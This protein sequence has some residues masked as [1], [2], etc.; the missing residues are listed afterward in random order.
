MSIRAARRRHHLEFAIVLCVALT[1]VSLV[2]EGHPYRV[3]LESPGLKSP[4]VEEVP[5]KSQVP[6]CD[7]DHFPC[8]IASIYPDPL[9]PEIAWDHKYD[10]KMRIPRGLGYYHRRAPVATA[11]ARIWGRLAPKA[12]IQPFNNESSIP[13]GVGYYPGEAEGTASATSRPEISQE[14]EV[15]EKFLPV[16]LGYY[17][18]EIPIRMSDTDGFDPDSQSYMRDSSFYYDAF[19]SAYPFNPENTPS[20]VHVDSA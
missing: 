6:P 4:L 12:D 5:K 3:I 7:S 19:R 14:P 11:D 20:F 15:D 16:G 18:S 2:L 9:S 10:K 8:D 17:E 1:S 13:L